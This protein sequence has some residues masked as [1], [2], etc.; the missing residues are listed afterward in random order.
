MPKVRERI[1]PFA[2]D[3][4]NAAAV[5]AVTAVRPAFLDVFLAPEAGDAIAALAGENLDSGFVD[6]FH[7]M[8]LYINFRHKQKSPTLR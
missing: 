1:E 4:I 3:E 8:Y 7:L 6:E 2:S 5:T